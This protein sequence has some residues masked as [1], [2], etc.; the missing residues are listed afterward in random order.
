[1]C[2]FFHLYL[3][4]YSYEYKLIMTENDWLDISIIIL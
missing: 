1:M 2:L 4:L 3:K